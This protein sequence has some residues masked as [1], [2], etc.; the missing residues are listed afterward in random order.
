VIAA[1]ATDLFGGT[2]MYQDAQSV[3]QMGAALHSASRKELSP[4]HPL[5]GGIRYVFLAFVSICAAVASVAEGSTT[6]LAQSN[7]R[8]VTAGLPVPGL[9]SQYNNWGPSAICAA[10][11]AGT[12]ITSAITTFNIAFL[13]ESSAFVSSPSNPRPDQLGGGVW[14][15]A[16]GGQNTI[17][18]SGVATPLGRIT[19]GNG[20]YTTSSQDRME[21]GGFQ[22]GLDIG[23][24]NFGASGVNV[25]F[26]VTGGYLAANSN[27]LVGFGSNNFS[28]PFVGGYFAAT[29][30]NFFFDA[31]FRD[32]FY[33]ISTTNSNAGYAGAGLNGNA[34]NITS[35]LGY[36][37]DVG[38][39]FVE[40]SVGVIWSHLTLGTLNQNGTPSGTGVY[41]PVGV[42]AGTLSFNAIDSVI[43][44][45][46]VRVGTTLQGNGVAWQPFVAASVWDEFAQNAVSTYTPTAN[47]T[48][49]ISTSTS[50][51]GVFG[52]F[53]AG[54]AAQVLNTGWLGYLRADYRT[55][56]NIQGWDLTGGLRYQFA[57]GEP[58]LPLVTKQTA[59]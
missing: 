38:Q 9:P 57:L 10:A 6:A 26:G 56:E 28:V 42:P 29:K 23:R 32:D 17:S 54:F 59:H 41:G 13:N 21:Y 51:V 37:F 31:Q 30:G 40:P 39:A 8:N 50:R 11:S 33:Q 47:N 35:S 4:G 44:R 19:G 27:E 55:G 12:S 34:P 24:F 45:A 14:F 48:F 3:Q 2:H 15:R 7:C 46:G 25:V 36:H 49:A 20:S 22:T 1:I 58:V 53:G 18:S 5:T 52:Q 16:V 43:G